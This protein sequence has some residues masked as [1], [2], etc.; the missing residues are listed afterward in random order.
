MRLTDVLVQDNNALV[1]EKCKEELLSAPLAD[2]VKLIENNASTIH[3][4]DKGS[5]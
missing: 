2:W 1:I 3:L 4:S 5:V